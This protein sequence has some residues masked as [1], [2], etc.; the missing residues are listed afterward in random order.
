MK[1]NSTEG[2]VV[3]SRDDQLKTYCTINT[4]ENHNNEKA[5]FFLQ[6][7]NNS[8]AY[9][10]INWEKAFKCCYCG[11]ASQRKVHFEYI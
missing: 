3:K 11:N 2:T 10:H 7:A 5:I 8:G 4:V 1:N 6:T 9:N